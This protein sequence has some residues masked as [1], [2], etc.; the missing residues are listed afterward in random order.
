MKTVQSLSRSFLKRYFHTLLLERRAS[1]I[2]QANYGLCGEL[3]S[4]LTF[5]LSQ[6]VFV[7]TTGTPGKG[8]ACTNPSFLPLTWGA[9]EH[10]KARCG[11]SLSG[12]LC[13][14][15]PTTGHGQGN[16]GPLYLGKNSCHSSSRREGRRSQNNRDM[17]YMAH[18][19][20]TLGTAT[21]SNQGLPLAM[22]QAGFG[23]SECT[24]Q[25]MP[26]TP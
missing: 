13:K 3:S 5:L 21:L 20:Q 25:M 14:G 6:V 17:F 11:L 18:F 23:P 2:S 24:A 22:L 16:L 19:P 10:C 26:K 12:F 8:W 7:D 15:T 9:K 4:G 1:F